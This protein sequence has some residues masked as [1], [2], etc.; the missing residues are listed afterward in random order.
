M[1]SG[2]GQ[3]AGAAWAAWANIRSLVR[4]NDGVLSMEHAGADEP[5]CNRLVASAH[6]LAWEGGDHQPLTFFIHPG[7]IHIVGSWGP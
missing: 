5:N 4:R 6:V 7:S 2:K 3:T 1:S